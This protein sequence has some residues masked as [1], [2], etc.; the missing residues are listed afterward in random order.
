MLSESTRTRPSHTT[1]RS[2]FFCFCN[3]EH[4]LRSVVTL[5]NQAMSGK[6]FP[7]LRV[8]PPVPRWVNRPSV[9]I[10]AGQ[11]PSYLKGIFDAFE[12]IQQTIQRSSCQGIFHKIVRKGL[13]AVVSLLLNL[14][15]E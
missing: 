13:L 3:N 8:L 4:H 6:V 7:N 12:P 9:K 5:E 10:N 2:R 14:W 15:K 11:L 1:F